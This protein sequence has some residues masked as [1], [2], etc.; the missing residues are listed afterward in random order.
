MKIKTTARCHC[1]PTG[2]AKTKKKKKKKG[3]QHQMLA[4]VKSNWNAL[5]LL[6]ENEM[7]QPC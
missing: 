1:T 2:I 6:A 7:V 5:T 3:R 4:A